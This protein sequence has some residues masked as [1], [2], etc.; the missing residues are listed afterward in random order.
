MFWVAVYL[1]LM[2]ILLVY[3]L[4]VTINGS[5]SI[6]RCIVWPVALPVKIITT[7]LFD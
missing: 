4:S 5:A 6:F 2:G 1:Y 3:M 7:L